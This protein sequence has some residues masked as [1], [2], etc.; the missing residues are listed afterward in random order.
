MA[1][2][3]FS[4]FIAAPCWSQAVAV[5]APELFPAARAAGHGRL[6]FWGIDVYDARLWVAPGFRPVDFAAHGF[7]LQLHYL[8]Q[9][10]GADI[11]RRSLEEMRRIGPIS[12]E[13][14]A[15]W[16]DGL[17]RL[18]PDVGAGDSITGVNQPGRGP[19]FLLNGK[20]LGEVGDARF[21]RLFF[22]IWLAP[23][24]SEPALRA[25]LLAGTQP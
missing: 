5:A 20:A 21:A 23:Q 3:A 14:A 10:R 4:L 2:T 19:L 18:L 6:R 12:A 7:A 25:A 11:A 24:T 17:A 1:A 9:F 15:A 13:Q 8:R 16:Q 22:G